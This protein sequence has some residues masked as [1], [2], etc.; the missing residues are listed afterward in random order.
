MPLRYQRFPENERNQYA[1]DKPKL[2]P[3]SFWAC[4]PW[5]EPLPVRSQWSRFLDLHRSEQSQ[6]M[7]QIGSLGCHV[8]S[9]RHGSNPSPIPYHLALEQQKRL[10]DWPESQNRAAH[11]HGQL[12]TKSWH[13]P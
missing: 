2:Q 8:S 9:D 12:Q 11:W 4:A 3:Q 10:L 5:Q 6:T 13:A 1:A 7:N